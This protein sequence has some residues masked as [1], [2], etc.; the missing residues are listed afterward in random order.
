MQGLTLELVRA[1]ARQRLLNRFLQVD[2]ELDHQY[3]GLV[4]VNLKNLSFRE[5][6]N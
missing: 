4:S 2:L 1:S 6:L 5:I 3:S